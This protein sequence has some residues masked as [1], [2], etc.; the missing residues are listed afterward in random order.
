MIR[1]IWKRVGWCLP[2]CIDLVTGCQVRASETNAAA[3][4]ADSLAK[5]T[6]VAT[7]AAAPSRPEIGF[8]SRQQLVEHYRKHGAEFEGFSQEEYLRAAQL[9]RDRAV[10]GPVLEISRGDGVRS[11]FDRTSGAFL[12]FDTDGTIRTFFRPND[13]E[14][15]FRRQARRRP[16]R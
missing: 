16:G 1:K 5:V 10:S 13:G 2:L 11:R 7:P 3:V 9:L 8:R 15:Y 4:V 14:S 6:A 12:A